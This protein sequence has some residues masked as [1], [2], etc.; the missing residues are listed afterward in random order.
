MVMTRGITEL[1]AIKVIE[2]QEDAFVIVKA[3]DERIPA[4]LRAGLA[5]EMY[6]LPVFWRHE[7]PQKEQFSHQPSFGRVVAAIPY[8]A[9]VMA[10]I[11]LFSSSEMPLINLKRKGL[12]E[13]IKKSLKEHAQIG[14]SLTYDSIFNKMENEARMIEIHPFELSVT[15]WPACDTCVI[16]MSEQIKKTQ[17]NDADK[18][19]KAA[20]DKA[21]KEASIEELQ[22]LLEKRGLEHEDEKAKATVV[23]TESAK[24]IAELEATAK[25]QGDEIV[26]IKAELEVTRKAKAEAERAPFVA[27]LKE[28][29]SGKLYDDEDIAVMSIAKIQDKTAKLKKSKELEAKIVVTSMAKTATENQEK[30]LS[31]KEAL[32][33]KMDSCEKGTASY[34]KYEL[35]LANLKE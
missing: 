18:T 22:A 29:D 12:I 35:E 32:K 26:K 21:L 15:P 10:A 23:A 4:E 17:E 3:I 27:A 24:K 6:N 28:L 13:L 2:S 8:P 1:Q 20:I 25:T 30:P 11:R 9:G 31:K 19:A 14:V 5:K 7:T 34:K 33:K 16:D